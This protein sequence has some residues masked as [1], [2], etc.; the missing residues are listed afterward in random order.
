MLNKEESDIFF[1]NEAMF[2]EDRTSIKTKVS[3]LYGRL[4]YA[5]V[6]LL[7]GFIIHFKGEEALVKYN[8]KQIKGK[9]T[10]N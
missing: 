4:A 9:S 1:D 7:I 8:K 6:E 3:K 5:K 2:N 10:L